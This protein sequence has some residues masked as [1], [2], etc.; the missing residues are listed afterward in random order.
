MKPDFG[1]PLGVELAR[2]AKAVGRSFDAALA[3][4][5]SSQSAWLILLALKTRP[6][7]NQ[8]EL[9]AAVDIQ[10]ATLTHH[11]DGMEESGLITRR[12]NPANRRVHLVELTPAG[13]AAFVR[14]RATAVAFDQTLRAGFTPE[15]TATL[16]GLLARL[17][18]NAT[19]STAVDAPPVFD[20]Q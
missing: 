13:E 2:S 3:A 12:L 1:T 14:L 20:P 11:L 19:G 4:S 18:A 16:R 8:R 5:G 17:R 10:S 15:E 6:I 7:A 9:A